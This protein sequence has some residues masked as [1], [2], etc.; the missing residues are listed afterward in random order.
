[1]YA[2]RTQWCAGCISGEDAPAVKNP[3]PGAAPAL[4]AMLARITRRLSPK[5]GSDGLSHRGFIVG[6]DQLLPTPDVRFD[7]LYA[8]SE[9]P[10]P[11]FIERH[12]PLGMSHSHVPISAAST[13]MSIRLACRSTVCSCTVSNLS[14]STILLLS[15]ATLALF[16]S[17]LVTVGCGVTD[18]GDKEVVATWRRPF[19]HR[20]RAV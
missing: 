11:S 19:V 10:G 5:M 17:F 2:G 9:H 12:M 1:M 8:I 20:G 6:M 16:E 15:W 13:I 7:F 4:Q 14:N 3:L 18:A